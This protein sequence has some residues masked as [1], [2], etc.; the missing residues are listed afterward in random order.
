MANYTKN[1]MKKL[2]G[3]VIMPNSAR[4]ASARAD[5]KKPPAHDLEQG[6]KWERGCPLSAHASW[7]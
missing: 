1:S 3:L 2:R 5:K 7:K 4:D 6:G